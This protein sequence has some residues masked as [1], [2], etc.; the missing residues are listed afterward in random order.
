MHGQSLISLINVWG[1]AWLQ[2]ALPMFVQSSLLIA[3][4]LGLDWLLRNR[5]RAAVRYGLL[6]LV[7]VKLVLP[8]SFALPT[9]LG[10]WIR[11]AGFNLSEVPMKPATTPA[12]LAAQRPPLVFR[13]AAA[14]PAVQGASE[15]AE[16]SNL[17][18]FPLTPA[19]A[20]LLVWAIGVAVLLAILLRRGWMLAQVMAQSSA[21]TPQEEALLRECVGQIRLH[22]R[23]RL[24]RTEV[25][26][27]PAVCGLFRPII[28]LPTRLAEMLSP[29]ELRAVLLHEL[30]HL[31]RGDLWVNGAQSLLQIIY[32]W[33]PLL[34]LAN[35][36]IRLVREEATDD[37][38][39]SAM[40]PD[41][42]EYPETLVHVAKFTLSR[43][44]LPLGQ[45]GI[46]ESRRKLTQR[47]Q[48]M[49]RQ[50][51]PAKAQ[52]GAA[53]LALIVLT[54]ALLL[55][56]AHGASKDLPAVS[57]PAVRAAQS[58]R[59][60]PQLASE[61]FRTGI[62]MPDGT[63]WSGEQ[64]RLAQMGHETNWIQIAVSWEHTVALKKDGT[65]WAWGSNRQGQFGNGQ[66]SGG[67]RESPL[68]VGTDADWAAVGVGRTF[69]V[70]L[71]KDG[72]LWTWGSDLFGQLG[73][74]TRGDPDQHAVQ[75]T[76]KRVGTDNDW[77]AISVRVCH[78]HALKKDGSLWGWGWNVTGSLGDGT[79]MYRHVPGPIGTDKDWV[80][81]VDANDYT[82]AL[83]QDGSL[84]AWGSNLDGQLGDGSREGK[85]V[86]TRI[87]NDRDWKIIA[88]GFAHSLALK[89]DG[90]LWNWGLNYF[91]QLG[92]GTTQDSLTPKRIGLDT[93]WA[94][95]CAGE[96]HALAAKRDGSVWFWGLKGEPG[97]ISWG[98]G[99]YVHGLNA[100]ERPPANPD[101]I[102]QSPVQLLA[103]GESPG[104]NSLNR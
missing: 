99:G 75:A 5:V 10:Y 33:H 32:W 63:L 37:A 77:S 29:S 87:G 9:G 39:L 84:W 8:V 11:P 52:L 28:V 43:P 68:Q 74:G 50:P 4:L 65:L 72:S 36:R 90:S 42:D 61:G 100:K 101:S 96:T 80:S 20:T 98:T 16:I 59:P 94:A 27:C 54:G 30:A 25:A 60:L 86:P 82:L 69:T 55:P 40:H 17:P 2:L 71:K 47:I 76:P 34:W 12:T 38:V 46:L 15:A 56:L 26:T 41:A 91:G 85:S 88:G 97:E 44:A 92:D 21:P 22:R 67:V 45:P 19:G 102:V 24:K 7:L 51:A 103:A 62:I 70:A 78:T 6:L 58:A 95:I 49:L 35:A 104:L 1:Q 18:A 14:S 31:R 57:P 48:R 53:G 23:V 79:G 64:N 3:V 66:T 83:K 81:V 89:Q 13:P 73:D 93:D